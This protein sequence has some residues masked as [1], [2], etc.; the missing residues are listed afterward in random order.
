MIS[1]LD[2][3][4]T[5]AQALTASVRV[6]GARALTQKKAL[7]VANWLLENSLAHFPDA[8]PAQHVNRDSSGKHFSLLRRLNPFWMKLTLGNPDRLLTRILPVC[9]WLFTSWAVTCG[10]MLI[11]G[12]LMVVMTELGPLHREFAFDLCSTQ[13]AVARSRLGPSEDRTRTGACLELQTVWW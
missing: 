3:R 7:E 5:L 2:G 4:T 10:L 13:L 9:G 1:L 6:L 8:G 11:C 12:G